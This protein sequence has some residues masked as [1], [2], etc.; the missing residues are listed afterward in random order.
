MLAVSGQHL[1]APCARSPD[2]ALETISVTKGEF[3]LTVS[4]KP[5]GIARVRERV[6]KISRR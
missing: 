3:T 6:N 2:T 4:D 5:R 1:S